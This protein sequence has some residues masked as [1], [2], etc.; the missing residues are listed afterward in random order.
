M[1]QTFSTKWKSSKQARKKRK[2]IAKA[3]LHIKQKFIS[4]HLSKELA[5][6][7]SKK[8]VKIRKGD[9]VKLVRGQ[10][11]NKTGKVERVMLKKSRIY[12]EN[13]QNLK[14]DGTKS[15]YPVH[16]SNVIITELDLSDKKRKNKLEVKNG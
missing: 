9:K 10:F 13:I 3:P 15:F 1:K 4:A 8:S 5:K 11:K 14:A 6:K 16:P 12:I 7:H 2:Y